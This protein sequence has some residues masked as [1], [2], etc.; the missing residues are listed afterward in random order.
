[1]V[2]SAL[3]TATAPIV[4]RRLRP[5]ERDAAAALLLELNRVE[6]ALTGDRNVSPDAGRECLCA[7]EAMLAS[8]GG[9]I[10]AALR[11]ERVVGVLVLVFDEAAAFVRPELRRHGRIADLAVAEGERG[12]GVGRRLIE[13]AERL[14]RAA[15]LQ[16]LLVGAV[17]TNTPALALYARTGFRPQIIELI[18]WLE[19]APPAPDGH[20]MPSPPDEAKRPRSEKGSG[21]ST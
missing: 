6:D 3:E 15:K 11:A 21:D 17:S 4:V 12:L 1:M 20:P 2:D 8:S 14:T 7:L 5:E 13:E 18:K 19:E 10:L 9:A 16:T